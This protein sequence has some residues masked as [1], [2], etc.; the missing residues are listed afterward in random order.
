[1][2]GNKILFVIALI[3]GTLGLVLGFIAYSDALTME[4]ANTVLP[5]GE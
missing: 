1:M 3:V 5:E 2:K 4:T